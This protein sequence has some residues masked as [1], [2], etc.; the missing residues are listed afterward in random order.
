MGMGIG[1]RGEGVRFLGFII[2]LIF[3][4]NRSIELNRGGR[5]ARGEK[6]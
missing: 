3:I 6:V 4:G 5:G 2:I 1:W